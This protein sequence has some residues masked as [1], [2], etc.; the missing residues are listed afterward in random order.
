MR[1]L[2]PHSGL[3]RMTEAH[4]GDSF[5]IL[6]SVRAQMSLSPNATQSEAGS[7]LFVTMT[8]FFFC[9]TSRHFFFVGAVIRDD[10]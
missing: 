2:I 8:S 7:F 9:L 5:R 6:G 3:E 10:D 4:C 1:P